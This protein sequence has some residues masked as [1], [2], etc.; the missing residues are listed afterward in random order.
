MLGATLR[1]VYQFGISNILILAAQEKVNN[2]VN[3]DSDDDDDDDDNTVT[4]LVSITI[5]LLVLCLIA[6]IITIVCVYRM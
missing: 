1:L 3:N 4:I 6:L 2:I 5:V